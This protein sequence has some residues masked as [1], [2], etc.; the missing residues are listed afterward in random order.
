MAIS[1]V[2]SKTFINVGATGTHSVSLT[3]LL[4]SA[5]A[6]ATLLP[7]DRVFLP[8]SVGTVARDLA[9]TAPT[10]FTEDTNLYKAGTS[11]D[12]NLIVW[13]KKMG[14]TPDTSVTIPASGNTADGL[15]MA[16]FAL[17]GLDPT[18]YL[19]VAIATATGSGAN[20]N[21]PNAPSVTPVTTGAWVMVIGAAGVGT[22]TVLV[23]PATLATTTNHYQANFSPDTNDGVLA[24]GLFE[25]WASGA[26]DPAAFTNG[27]GNTTG[28][29]CAASIA[30]R[31]AAATLAMPLYD[32]LRTMRHLLVR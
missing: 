7:D 9:P 2:G 12:S 18:T 26:Y 28:A 22:G 31:P 4:D 16:P 30:L 15:I 1:F 3:D 6:S 17:R 10:G 24:V 8:W 32:P 14:A 25:T 23:A 11:F 13:S 27:T 21:N 5:G 20:P 19:D 29:W